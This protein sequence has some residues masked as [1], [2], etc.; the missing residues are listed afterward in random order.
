MEGK[1][2]HCSTFQKQISMMLDGALDEATAAALRVHMEACGD[3]R[4]FH[5][6]IAFMDA[7]LESAAMAYPRPVLAEKIKANIADQRARK[8]EREP[9]PAWSRV[10]L[11][12]L[13][14]FLA[15]GLG[16]LAGQSLNEMFTHQRADIVLDQLLFS[17]NGWVSDAFMEMGGQ[18]QLR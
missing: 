16:N 1:A 11:A 18:E 13:V 12:A 7:T 3:C 5:D 10:S 9:F 2:M 15:I 8:A 17:Q 6:R 14:L 4:K